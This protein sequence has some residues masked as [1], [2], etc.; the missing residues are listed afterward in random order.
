MLRVRALVT[1][2]TGFI[3]SH[4]CERLA[5]AGNR[6]RALVRPS[7]D[8]A[9]LSQ[10]EAEL[11]RGD[12]RDPE[13]LSSSLRGVDVVFHN[14][15]RVADWG[16]WEDFAAVG[17]QGTEN[18]LHAALEHGVPRFVHMS[19]ASVYGLRRIRRRTVTEA[20]GP[21]PRPGRWDHYARAKIAAERTVLRRGAE[22]GIGV[23]LLRP[24]AV[25]GP[26][27]RTVV[28]RLAALLTD[29]RLRLVGDGSNPILGVYV[30]D[31]ADAAVRAAGLP[32]AVGQ[33]YQLDGP[34]DLSQAEFMFLLA[35]MLGQPR[36]LPGLPVDVLYVLAFL[37][38]FWAH[39]NRRAEPPGLTRYLVALTGGQA[40]FDDTKARVELGWKPRTLREGLELTREWIG[41]L[42]QKPTTSQRLGS[43]ESA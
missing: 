33:T 32:E 34:G 43:G 6:V 16:R 27:D 29:R 36:P 7:S 23:T 11:A 31:V 18:L 24:T 8:V 28:P 5:A 26:R 37:N 14:A 3:G 17:V 25:F 41:S 12:L 35:D 38:E 30:G 22:G 10:M 4:I 1:G 20:K 15:A 39:L 42:R 13:S 9:N 21:N 40:F 19:S 2:A